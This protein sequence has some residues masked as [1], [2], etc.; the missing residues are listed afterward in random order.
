MFPM[1][2]NENDWTSE[3]QKD[4]IKYISSLIPTRENQKKKINCR[5][6]LRLLPTAHLENGTNGV[7]DASAKT[8]TDSTKDLNEDKYKGYNLAVIFT[9]GT[10]M[11]ID[12]GAKTGTKAGAGW[13]VDQWIG[14]Y[15]KY[16]GYTY[17]IKSNTA[18]VL[19][20]SDPYSTLVSA[21]IAY[22]IEKYFEI[23]KHSETVYTLIDD[24]SELVSGTYD[25]YVDFALTR[26]MDSKFRYTQPKFKFTEEE[27]KTAYSLLLEQI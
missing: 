13:T 3:Q 12:A 27:W 8:L 4:K 7:I 10:G 11:V 19:T 23:E 25:Y 6:R 1:E 9:S 20:L 16:D 2:W 14:Y 22:S 17:Y 15:L 26:V 21:T 5:V 24:D 18:T